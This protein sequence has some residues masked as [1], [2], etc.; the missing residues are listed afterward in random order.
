MAFFLPNVQHTPNTL[1]TNAQLT[2]LIFA[3]DD[4]LADKVMILAELP[5]QHHS[6]SDAHLSVEFLPQ[7]A[8]TF[9]QLG[10]KS[11]IPD[12]QS[13]KRQTLALA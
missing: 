3:E 11:E 2:V 6:I 9:F 5:H 8:D 4:V 7:S 13:R 1:C 12:N 10:Q